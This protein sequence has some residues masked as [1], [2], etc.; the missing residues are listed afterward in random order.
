[1]KAKQSEQGVL[2]LQDSSFNEE[3][4]WGMLMSND[5]ELVLLGLSLLWKN[6]GWHWLLSKATSNTTSITTRWR[7]LRTLEINTL[8]KNAYCFMGDDDSRMILI[9]TRISFWE[10]L[11]IPEEEEKKYSVSVIRF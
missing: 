4:A 10:Q 11:E 1:M 2:C 8:C 6:K 5:A 3:K 9:S 7:R